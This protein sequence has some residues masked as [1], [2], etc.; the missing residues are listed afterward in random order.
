[1]VSLRSKRSDPATFLALPGRERVLALEALLLLP[2]VEL[3]LRRSGY[4]RTCRRLTRLSRRGRWRGPAE[5]LVPASVKMVALSASRTPVPAKCLGHSLT[6]W[7]LLR[8]RGIEGEV[9]IGV[10]AGGD[11]LDAHAWVEV[12]GQPI[13]ETQETVD[14]YARFAPGPSA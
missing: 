4:D 7:A 14:S 13:N 8:R 5:D 2:L 10:R 6:L 12:D 3:S 11:P 1:V 9:V